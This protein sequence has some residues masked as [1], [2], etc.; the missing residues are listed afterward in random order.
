MTRSNL[1]ILLVLI[2]MII[3]SAY[4]SA[5][6]TAF[7]SLNRVRMKSRADKGDRKAARVLSM[8]ENY[9]RILSTILVGN[10][11]VNMVAATLSTLLFISLLGSSKG[12]T[13]STVVLTVIILVFSE[14]SPK[15]LAKE[16]PEAFA[17][18]S[19]PFLRILMILFTPVN[20]LLSKWKQLLSSLFRKKPEDGI[21]D[22]ELVTYVSVAETQGLLDRDESQLIRSAIRFDDIESKD[23]LTPRVDIVSIGDT[24]TTEEA[25]SV[26]ASKGYSRIPVFHETPDN[27]IGILHQKDLFSARY[28]GRCDLLPLIRPVLYITG[29][30]KIDDLLRKFQMSKTHMAIVVD[31]YGGTE[32]LVTLE[33]VVEE[34]VGE[35]W[36]EQ[37]EVV[38][39]IRKQPDGSY[40]VD[41]SS[42]ADDFC[43]LFS[44]KW[45][46]GAVSISG[47]VMEKLGQ[48]P[49]TGDHFISDHLDVTVTKVENHR[50]L[51]IQVRPLL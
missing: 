7:T 35:I 21:T 13:V 22:D 31:E 14:V 47:W 27:I 28:Y 5:T 45:D 24:V 34:L 36:D 41:C 15:S 9:D 33:D 37:D 48:I 12:P 51:E 26:F 20:F 30:E 8:S 50:V 6:E 3:L 32:G 1:I 25:V 18:F 19:S 43:E 11:I 16:S 49:T 46:C 29:S 40:L 4:F 39:L 2:L 23:I 10:N 38:E 42:D 17:V 44:M